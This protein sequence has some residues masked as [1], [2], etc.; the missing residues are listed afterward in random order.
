MVP[1][2]ELRPRM[3]SEA[4]GCPKDVIDRAVIDAARYLC[5]QTYVWREDIGEDVDV[6][7][8][9]PEYSVPIDVDAGPTGLILDPDFTLV[10]LGFLTTTSAFWQVNNPT[11]FEIIND[12]DAGGARAARLALGPSPPNQ[13]QSLR[14]PLANMVA[15]ESGDL[16]DISV[17]YRVVSR[18]DD[19]QSVD[20]LFMAVTPRDYLGN[21]I[22]SPT[23]PKSELRLPL[24]GV[25]A[26]VFIKTAVFR[27]VTIGDPS[28]AFARIRLGA[29]PTEDASEL[30]VY[31]IRATPQVSKADREV[32]TVRYVEFYDDTNGVDS[33]H[34]LKPASDITR[35]L[36]I[37]WRKASGPPVGFLVEN[38]GKIRLIPNPDVDGTI[39]NLNVAFKPS[40]SATEL[41]DI[42]VAQWEELIINGALS[43]LLRQKGKAWSNDQRGLDLWKGFRDDVAVVRRRERIAFQRQSATV[44]LPS[45]RPY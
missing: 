18:L 11:T 3:L 34:E 26:T 4:M 16:I 15:F 30:R 28:L 37:S 10:S 36:P 24:D 9:I 23:Y 8:G 19:V 33:R 22:T 5:E 13:G 1:V 17:K 43:Y 29:L 41:A 35:K 20:T 38:L 7:A 21:T 39:T 14:V 31:E 44:L 32:V 6:T 12:A 45:E 27:G 40:H 2:S 25:T 42:L